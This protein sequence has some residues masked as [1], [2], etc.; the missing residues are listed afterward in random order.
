MKSRITRTEF[1]ILVCYFL[2]CLIFIFET[3]QFDNGELSFYVRLSKYLILAVLLLSVFWRTELDYAQVTKL[4][5]YF[6]ISGLIALK[7]GRLSDVI[8]VA[9]FAYSGIK[10]K[11][12]LFINVYI[13]AVLICSFLVLFGVFTGLYINEFIV[14]SARGSRFFLGFS[15]T[16]ILPNF[17]FHALLAYT[18]KRE[19]KFN[20]LESLI[21]IAVNEVLYYYTQT[22]A[23]YYEVILLV[24]SLWILDLFPRMFKSKLFG[25]LCLFAFPVAAFTIIYL[26]YEYS[27][28]NSFYQL[29][30][31]VLSN[32]RAL[33]NLAIKRYGITAFGSKVEWATGRFGIERFSEYFYVD[34]SFLN[35]LICFGVVTCVYIVFSFGIISWQAYLKNNYCLCLALL[36]LAL[37]SLTDPQLFELRYNPFILLI[38]HVVFD[39]SYTILQ[40][41]QWIT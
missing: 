38:G 21:I 25:M 20:A 28:S 32:R 8:L 3:T 17:L 12:S 35:I 27:P 33:G 14:E 26:S 18:A 9:A 23:V 39:N 37:H 24:L 15:Y 31:R 13:S 19:K 29:I 1:A 16:T 5:L 2:Y 40:P 10:L 7:S 41:K 34:S 22:R 30:N 36:F 4:L 11:T 6:G